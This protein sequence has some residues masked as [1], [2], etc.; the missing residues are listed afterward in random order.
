MMTPYRVEPEVVMAY[1]HRTGFAGF[2]EFLERKGAIKMTRGIE[3]LNAK[4]E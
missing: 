3:C 4:P 2:G 1:E